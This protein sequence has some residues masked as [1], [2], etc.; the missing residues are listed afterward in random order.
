MLW[1]YILAIVGLAGF[2]LA[3]K[4][5]WWSWYINLGA[6]VLWFAYAIITKQYGFIIGA[7]VYSV[8]FAQNAIK[9]TRDHK[10]SL[11]IDPQ[12]WSQEKKI[13]F[14]KDWDARYNETLKE[15]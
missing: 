8:V 3:G 14:R 15:E 13:Q 10:K 4:R 5:V 11:L 7:V 6:Q 9:W 12:P 1:S 2:V